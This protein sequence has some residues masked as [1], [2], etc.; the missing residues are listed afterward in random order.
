[1]AENK[2][3]RVKIETEVVVLAKD[4]AHANE[5]AESYRLP[6]RHAAARWDQID[7]WEIDVDREVHSVFDLPPDWEPG[8]IPW[9]VPYGKD[10]TIAQIWGPQETLSG[11]EAIIWKAIEDLHRDH[12]HRLFWPSGFKGQGFDEE[13]AQGVLLKLEEAGRLRAFVTVQDDSGD[14]WRG[15]IAEFD[16][17]N[18]PEDEF[19][20]DLQFELAPYHGWSKGAAK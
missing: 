13:R 19:T 15:P 7:H 12:G 4:E 8:A 2:L 1:M 9:G 18:W 20:H 11:D 14:V 3:Y 5:V 10:L 6:S 17:P 16:Q